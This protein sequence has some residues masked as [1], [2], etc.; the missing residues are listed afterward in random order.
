M[1]FVGPIGKLEPSGAD[2][3]TDSGEGPKDPEPFPPSVYDRSI[4]E[5]YGEVFFP[6]SRK[7][8]VEKRWALANR[9]R[10]KKE[11]KS[12]VEQGRK[13]GNN[14]GDKNVAGVERTTKGNGKAKAI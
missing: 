5:N 4:I 9:E 10:K 8:E 13:N 1:G 2:V 7:K 11:G 3:T 6:R 12:V 14:N